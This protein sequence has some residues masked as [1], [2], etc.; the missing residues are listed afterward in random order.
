M[1]E[2]LRTG[3]SAAA[4]TQTVRTVLVDGVVAGSWAILSDDGDATLVVGLAVQ[5]TRTD[6]E[7]LASEGAALLALLANSAASHEVRIS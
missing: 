4:G 6:R 1:S 5:T 7:A 2:G 3:L